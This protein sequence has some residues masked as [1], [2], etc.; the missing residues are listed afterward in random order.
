MN[1]WKLEKEESV[2]GVT[3]YDMSIFIQEFDTANKT[4]YLAEY[5]EHYSSMSEHFAELMQYAGLGNTY[6]GLDGNDGYSATAGTDFIF[7]K[8]GSDTLYGNGGNDILRGM[9]GNDN[10]HGGDG[11][12]I[13][14]GGN[15]KD[16]LYGESGNDTLYGESGNDIFDGGSGNDILI[17]SDGDDTF[18]FGRGY[19]HDE[20]RDEGGKNSI[21][22]AGLSPRDIS[23]NGINDFDVR[24]TIKS[25]GETLTIKNFRKD[26]TLADYTLIFD[27]VTMHCTDEKSP[28]RHIYGG[29]GDDVLKVMQFP[30]QPCIHLAEMIP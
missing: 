23:V 13:L 14:S 28:F 16:S 20:I 19:G 26:E 1:D 4:S 27:N 21:R 10:L 17:D 2:G 30:T 15:D 12:D 9:D 6:L 3:L 11:N 18:V 8:E 22:F 5:K 24:I 7:G 25:T 29:D